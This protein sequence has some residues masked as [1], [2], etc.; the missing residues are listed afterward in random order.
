MVDANFSIA[1]YNLHPP[2]AILL[3]RFFLLPLLKTAMKRLLSPLFGSQAAAASQWRVKR[4]RLAV[5]ALEDRTAPSAVSWLVIANN[6]GGLPDRLADQISAAG[7]VLTSMMPQTGVAVA[8]SA[9][10]NFAATA[11]RIPGV[12]S[13]V[14]DAPISYADG[15]DPVTPLDVGATNQARPDLTGFQWA[16]DAI[17]AKDA[18]DLGV[19]G[20]GVRVVVMDGS[21]MTNHPDLKYDPVQ[22]RGL[23]VGLS[24]SFVPDVPDKPHEGVEFVPGGISGNFSHATHVAGIIA[25]ANNGFGTTGVA[26]D[27]ELVLAKT[28]RDFDQTIQPSAVIQALLYAVEID[29]DVVNMSWGV[30]LPRSYGIYT[31]DPQWYSPAIITA[32]ARATNYAHQQGV[33]LVGSAGNNSLDFDHSQ[34]WTRTGHWYHIPSGLPHVISVSA[35]GPLGWGRDHSTDLDLPASYTNYGQSVIDLAAPGGYGDP[36]HDRE[37]FTVDGVT[38]PFAYV[39]DMVLSTSTQFSPVGPYEPE[40]TWDWRRGT[41]MAA[42]HVAGIAALII[43]ANGGDMHPNQVRT[44]LEQ[45]AD[46]LGKP[47]QD[48]F[49]GHGRVN[50]FKAV[51]LVR[52]A[53]D[54]SVLPETTVSTTA[55]LTSPE[56][57]ALASVL[58]SGQT[59]PAVTELPDAAW[60]LETMWDSSA[61]WALA[62]RDD[63]EV[64]DHLFAILGELEGPWEL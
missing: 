55:W 47:G 21:I 28:G 9:D 23:N 27:V 5:E 1:A 45:S 32:L 52:A 10:P 3:T 46:D 15:I 33:T 16:L 56:S 30:L 11:S 2:D 18:W 51:S 31:W 26:P 19:T 12:R 22:G 60:A 25:A 53:P 54:L 24:K 63:P 59:V 29:A 13:V 41:S 17:Q 34:D 14:P 8:E 44:I 35:T 20:R 58:F 37:P 7:G 6:A 64:L 38:L 42:P 40:G 50:A 36:V 49:Y 62:L 61:A 48:D 43:S 4:N 57:S 39:F